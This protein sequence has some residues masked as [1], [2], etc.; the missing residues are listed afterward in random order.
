M[1]NRPPSFI[2]IIKTRFLAR[3]VL[4]AAAGLG[5]SACYTSPSLKVDQLQAEVPSAWAVEGASEAVF[6]PGSWVSDFNDPRLES[7]LEEALE[8][9]FDLKIA[10]SRLEAALANTR[11]GRSEVWPSLNLSGNGSESRRNPTASGTSQ[12]PVNESYGLN[13]R[14]NWE[15]DIWGKLRN[16]YRGDLADA[17][18]ALADYE[19][20]RLS[21]LG[22]VAKAWY[23]AVEAHQQFELEKRILDALTQSSRIVEENFSSGIASA[24]D[25]RLIRAN[26]ASSQSSL[27]GRRRSRQDAITNLETLLGRYP[28]S[29]LDIVSTFPDLNNTIPAGLP[30]ELLLRR[31]DV[32]SAERSLAAAEQR[33]FQ[34][35]KARLPSLDL[36]LSRGTSVQ[37]LS[38]IFK[39]AEQRIWSQSLN[40]AQTLF[41]GGR[42]KAN[43]R[44]A[45]A[46]HEQAVATYANTVLTAFRE[47][48][49]S[50]SY[51]DSFARD[52]E[53]L[54][55]AAFE[56]V[57]AEKLAWEEYSSGLS[58]IT[59]VLDSVRRSITAQRSYIQVANRRIQSRI[60]LYLAL[61][62]G[63]G[64]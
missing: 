42:L 43:F 32:V 45:R 18:M 56:S 48:E 39:V 10:A 7:I 36:S 47:V 8:Y 30:S 24:L 1:P 11:A 14:F 28:K 61:G 4:P 22:R 46:Q 54:K 16:G 15:I 62:G 63:F 5:L 19:A 49:N 3:V 41:E 52:Y 37:D 17:E 38:D 6:E 40:V 31:P 58:T 51:Q 60:D 64:A 55:V 23:E 50:L 20:A 21:L 29:E 35:S 34:T 9:N 12:T 57:E 27:E 59:T 53:A 13:A 44:R 33:K 25:V 2:R 26:L